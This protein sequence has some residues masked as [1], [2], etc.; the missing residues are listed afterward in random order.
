[1]KLKPL[2]WTI[3]LLAVLVGTIFWLSPKYDQAPAVAGQPL[4]IPETVDNTTQ[5]LIK[6]ADAEPIQLQKDSAGF[7]TLPNYHNLPVSFNRLQSFVRQ[8]TEATLVRSVTKAPERLARLELGKYHLIFRE[9]GSD[10]PIWSLETGKH[11]ASGGLFIRRDSQPEA[12]LAELNLYLDTNPE[13][14]V[15]KKV[16][17]F[18]TEDIA[19]ATI[20]FTNGSPPLVLKRVDAS[21][22][23][24]AENLPEGQQ[25]QQTEVNHILATL[26]GA[27]FTDVLEN[28]EPDTAT[29]LAQAQPY[30]LSLKLFNGD[31]YTLNIGHSHTSEAAL[32]TSTKAD[33]ASTT[34]DTQIS[35]SVPTTEVAEAQPNKKRFFGLFGKRKAKTQFT[36]V[37]PGNA[38]AE[39]TDVPIALAKDQLEASSENNSTTSV[40]ADSTI[41]IT[42][43]STALEP[44]WQRALEHITLVYPDAVF[45]ALPA[46]P[47]QLL[48]LIKQ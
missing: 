14:W 23:F 19:Q 22:P 46:S 7:W 10:A 33:A 43:A 1:M 12:L 13:S 8:L 25:L 3:A 24:T 29:L 41:F 6:K 32:A 35:T 21:A 18:R 36:P 26:T 39:Q 4:L 11:G 17:A 31:L 9:A 34:P 15:E 47:E 5:V 44:P 38:S 48:E 42:Y 40:P 37:S 45:T 16:L 28:Q 20:P 30:R 2:A 27:Y